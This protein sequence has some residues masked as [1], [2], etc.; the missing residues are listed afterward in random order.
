MES[1]RGAAGAGAAVRPPDVATRRSW[2]S[3]LTSRSPSMS[4]RSTRTP[5]RSSRSR[6]RGAGCP[7]RLPVPELMSPTRGR[8]ASSHASDVALPDPWW[9]TLSTSSGRS[10]PPMPIASSRGS[11]SSSMSPVSSIRRSPKRRSSTTEVSLTRLPSEG[12]RSGTSRLMGHSTSAR[13]PSKDSRSPAAR[14]PVARPIVDSRSRNAA[15]PGPDPSIP[16]SAMPETR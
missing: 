5:R 2:P 4:V 16:F 11:T 13:M 7:Y 6:V 10:S 1:G 12:D 8:S 14:W 9:A 15:S 3:V